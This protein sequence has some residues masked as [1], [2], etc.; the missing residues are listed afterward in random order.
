MKWL[1]AN[2]YCAKSAGYL[3]VI[4]GEKEAERIATKVGYP[5]MIKA[6]AGGGGKGMRVVHKSSEVSQAYR[7]AT[8]EARNSFKDERIFIEKYIERPRHI[9]VQ[10]LAD[11]FGNTVCLGERECS[12]QRHH[13]KVIEEA[14][15]PFIDEKTRQN[16]YKQCISLAKKVG[17]YSAGTV[18]FIVDTQK[19]FFF[20]EMNTRLQVE[21]PVTELVTGYDIVEQMI[22]VAAGEKLG[23][24]QKDVQL[25][26]W[27]MECRIYAEDPTRGF[28]PS[29]GRISEYK[30]PEAS[31][32]VRVDSGVYEGG[33]VSMFYDAMI[34]KLCTYAETRKKA[35]EHMQAALGDYVIHGISH[36]ISFLEAIMAHSRFASGDIT[37][38]F[39]AE[40]YPEG[41]FG[42]K[43][44][45]ETTKAFIA[46]AVAYH[47]MDANRAVTISGQML[48]RERQIGNRCVV[49]LDDE[50]DF[51]VYA[52]QR[53]GMLYIKHDTE[54]L[55]LRTE[56]T[57]GN[58]LFR[59]NVNGKNVSVKIEQF[60]GGIYLTHAGA[61]V[62]ARIA[63]PRV[64]ELEV[65][66]GHGGPC[67]RPVHH[68]RR[69]SKCQR[70]NVQA[71]SAR[72]AMR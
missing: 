34:A 9:E 51:P 50:M 49:T 19:N 10:V 28:L 56:W 40:E 22:R 57:L 48:G 60:P 14:P 16:M 42:A 53:D 39:I 35:I 52:R 44:T 61:R 18:E 12:I 1:I 54:Y 66:V 72:S 33:Q 71:L 26:G 31:R 30:E 65:S 55:A 6:A 38:N 21:H 37:T 64:A 69:K 23:F 15:S 3:G 11:Q 4:K 41:F 62:K 5:V 8:N 43:I 59:G 29:S 25:Q 63:T 45:S 68:R 67:R 24:S 20:L 47:F 32:N 13:Q 27:A 7:S 46:V 58:R 36:N 17:Y 2:W 70:P